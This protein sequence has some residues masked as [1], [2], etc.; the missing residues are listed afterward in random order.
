MKAKPVE[1]KGRGARSNPAGRFE[2]TTSEVV[3]DGWTAESPAGRIP[4][5]IHPDRA[6]SVITRNTSPDVPF[7]QSINP[8]RGCEHGCVY[9][10]ARPSHAYL[11][12][13][14]GLDFET[15][16]FFKVDAA[17]RLVEEL[18]A[19]GYRCK[20][21]AFGTNTDPY[22]PVERRLEVMRRLLEVL[23][24]CRHPLSIVTKGSLIDRDVD[25]LGEMARDG[26]VSV[27]IS[28]TTL[29]NA[30]KSTLEPRAAAPAARLASV[31]KLAA[32]GVPTGVLVAPVIPGINDDEIEDIATASAQAGAVR[33]GY[34][35]LRLPWEVGELFRDWLE[36]HAPQKASRVMHLI[37]Q[38]RGGRDY[39]SAWGRRQTGIGPYAELL[40]RRFEL[41]R[42]RVG[43]NDRRE[44]ELRNDLFVP[45]G[46]S[47]QLSLL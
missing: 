27:M 3:D 12:L 1:R 46:R 8:Y 13:S 30:L 37:R 31:R 4:T 40:R 26:L 25:V 10:F 24:H 35:L 23:Q 16:I 6:R 41:V 5:E 33:L 28:I 2:R 19:P 44:A 43:L 32:A 38:M 9:C 18:S 36:T 17:K 14:P 47:G 7:D 11:D 45:P 29:D 42:R 21:I 20:P 22:Q 39:D 15:K 34:V